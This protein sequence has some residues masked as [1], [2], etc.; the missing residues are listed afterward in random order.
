MITE[1][2]RVHKETYFLNCPPPREQGWSPLEAQVDLEALAD[3]EAQQGLLAP[4][5]LSYQLNPVAQ[6]A[7]SPLWVRAA[8]DC[9][10]CH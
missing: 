2:R 5:H 7:R 1:F 4:P 10:R 3:P 6:E 9:Q 8:P